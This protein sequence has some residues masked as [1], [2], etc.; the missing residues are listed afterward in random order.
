M[1]IKYIYHHYILWACA[2]SLWWWWWWFS[3]YITHSFSPVFIYISVYL[4]FLF[5]KSKNHVY[6]QKKQNK[7]RL[8][9]DI[10][11][12]TPL[13]SWL[14]INS[15]NAGRLRWTF[16]SIYSIIYIKYT[17]HLFAFRVYI[18]IHTHTHRWMKR[19]KEWKKKRKSASFSHSTIGTKLVWFKTFIV[20]DMSPQD[21]P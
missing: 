4:S 3:G 16:P 20:I 9:A 7:M 6:N 18:P 13:E 2:I 15:G 11:T 1:L 12:A 8:K 21:C 5:L 14:I 17:I 19:G 10:H